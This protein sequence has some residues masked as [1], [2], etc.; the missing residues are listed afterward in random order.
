[1]LNSYRHPEPTVG[2]T[3]RR[4]GSAS[5]ST[6]FVTL[7]ISCPCQGARP[8][9]VKPIV[10]PEDSRVMT[11]V[12]HSAF[13][14]RPRLFSQPFGDERLTLTGHATEQC[15]L[16]SALDAYVRHF[17]VVIPTDAVAHLD[18]DL[19]AAGL[20]MMQRKYVRQVDRGSKVPRLDAI[21]GLPPLTRSR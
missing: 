7:G 11:K 16:Y 19:G 12:R 6:I 21:A 10:P 1:M 18:D 20:T 8:D 4:F 17:S 2:V 3:S 14:R 13:I 15:I 9:L 5:D